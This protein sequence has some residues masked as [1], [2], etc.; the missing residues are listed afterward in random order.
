MIRH[1]LR[2]EYQNMTKPCKEIKRCAREN[3]THHYGIPMGALLV[4]GLIPLAIE[5]PFSMTAG[6]HPTLMQ[7]VLLAIADLL[8]ALISCI[9]SAGLTYLHL[10]MARNKPYQLSMIFWG[11]KNR[12]DR[13]ILASLLICLC[14]LPGLVPC[15]IGVGILYIPGIPG[16]LAIFGAILLGICSVLLC[17]VILLNVTFFI[18]VLIDQPEDS[19]PACLLASLHA[20]KGH[21]GKLLYLYLSFLGLDMLNLLSLGIGSLWIFPYKTQTF[22]TF[23]LS[24]KEDKAPGQTINLSL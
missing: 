9:L 13:F 10:N 21:R 17:T 4:A 18:Y 8:I 3:L 12:P 2:L 24:L 5:L 11:F 1:N 7:Q 6:E 16:I 22:A 19:I 15:I 23:Y 20:I 14:Y